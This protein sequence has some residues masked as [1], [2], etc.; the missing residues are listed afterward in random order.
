MGM[1]MCFVLLLSISILKRIKTTC[2]YKGSCG[3]LLSN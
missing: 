3:I 2:E 1:V